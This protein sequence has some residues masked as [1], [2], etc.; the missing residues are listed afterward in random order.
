MR[1]TRSA[2][3]PAVCACACRRACVCAPPS[4]WKQRCRLCW[5]ADNVAVAWRCCHLASV[6]DGC[7]RRRTA[8]LL[9]QPS[10]HRLP[11]P[12][13]QWHG[14]KDERLKIEMKFEM[15]IETRGGKKSN[16]DATGKVNSWNKPLVS[17]FSLCEIAIT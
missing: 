1:R 4:S 14:R 7:E 3:T 9:C 8:V 13:A 10:D 6:Q 16:A 11:R 2:R 17:S 15:C 12:R 5:R